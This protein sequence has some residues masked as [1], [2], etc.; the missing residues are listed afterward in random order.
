M[1]SVYVVK[2]YDLFDLAFPHGFV[3]K[4]TTD[5]IH[6]IDRYVRRALEKGFFIER[7]QAEQDSSFKQIIP[8]TLVVCGEEVL[9]LKRLS[10]GGE[11]R[12]RGMLSIGVGGHI[13]PSDAS[14]DRNL[15]A[16]G[17]LRELEEEVRVQEPS[18]PVPVGVVN[19]ESNPVGSVHFGLVHLLRISSPQV[20][21]LESNELEGRFVPAKEIQQMV[22]SKENF[23]TWSALVS[24][25][26]TGILSL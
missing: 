6:D 14:C 21:V 25:H 17:A 2:R 4:K 1:E 12:L 26:L 13:N 23:E 20:T 9:L 24:P 15:I 22:E 8:Y 3:S 10:G 5:P 18:D 7:R 16:A 19:D 11:P